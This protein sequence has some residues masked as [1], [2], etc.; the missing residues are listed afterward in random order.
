M[1]YLLCYHAKTE[2][3]APRICPCL[4]RIPD[5]DLAQLLIFGLGLC[6][7]FWGPCCYFEDQLNHLSIC[8]DWVGPSL[9]IRNGSSYIC[10]VP[11]CPVYSEVPV[12]NFELKTKKRQTAPKFRDHWGPYPWCYYIQDKPLLA[13]TFCGDRT[14]N[15]L[16]NNWILRPRVL[17]AHLQDGWSLKS[18]KFSVCRS[19]SKNP[20]N[21]EARQLNLLPP[22]MRM[23]DNRNLQ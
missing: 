6:F 7:A 15:R 21:H 22:H 11:I 23:T 3:L 18:S 20:G 13:C 10:L 16:T 17:S 9:L 4:D 14:L 5:L 12:L 2:H 8:E 1:G 19:L